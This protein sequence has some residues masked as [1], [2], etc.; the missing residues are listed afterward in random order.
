[1]RVLVTGT[2]SGLGK[3]LRRAFDAEAL[4]RRALEVDLPRLVRSTFDVIVHCATDA[5]KELPAHELPAYR[6]SNLTLTERLLDVPHQRFVYVSSQA[7]YP[8]DGRPWSEDDALQLNSEITLYGVFKLLAEDVVRRRARC[9]LVLR[10]SSLVGAEG[11]AN[12]IMRILR[13]EPGCLF[14]SGACPY[15]LVTYS[16]VEHFI[17][18]SFEKGRS[19]T[20]NI[21][22]TDWSTLQ[23]IAGHLG[24]EVEFGEHVYSAPRA[25]LSKVHATTDIFN[26][27]TLEVADR[28]ARELAVLTS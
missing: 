7:V 23:E 9:P 14:L 8:S 10:P 4:D 2:S 22:S 19:G 24:V 13:R 17:R 21:G 1:M 3:A 18:E 5:R 25:D 12:N 20:F 11:R 27:T 15:N 16:Q 26:A 28:V 6:D